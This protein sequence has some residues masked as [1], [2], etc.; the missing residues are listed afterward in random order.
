[1]GLAGT[2]IYGPASLGPNP[3]ASFTITQPIPMSAP[4]G[5]YTLFIELMDFTAGPP[6]VSCALQTV[7]IVVVPPR[8]AALDDTATG[9]EARPATGG[10]FAASSG[11]TVRPM[12]GVSASPNPFPGRT[13]LTFTLAEASPVRLA[14]YDVLG[15][16]VALLVD[17]TVEAGAHAAVFEV[18]G[19]AAGTYVYRLVAGSD[20]QPG[21]M[22]LTR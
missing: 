9:P 20:V 8:V 3:G 15:R 16:E 5:T 22:T 14:V 13:T 18:S 12:V 6:G 4:L 7:T 2:F 1:M 21:R 10:L 11:A 19:L 17:G